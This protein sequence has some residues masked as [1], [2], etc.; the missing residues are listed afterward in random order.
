MADD[1]ASASPT[2]VV[3]DQRLPLR[4]VVHECVDMSFFEIGSDRRAMS[5]RSYSWPA[6][7]RALFSTTDCAINMPVLWPRAPRV[8]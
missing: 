7:P 1:G 4:I 6:G 8:S 5:P 2:D 3:H